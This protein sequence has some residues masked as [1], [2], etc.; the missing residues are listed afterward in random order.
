MYPLL[1][2]RFR[3]GFL[4]IG[5]HTLAILLFSPVFTMLAKSY[6]PLL[7]FDPTGILFLVTATALAVGGSLAIEQMLY[8]SGLSR[9]FFGK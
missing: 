7:S 3:R 5:L 2:I 4:Y 9:Y 8:R 1:A 6:L